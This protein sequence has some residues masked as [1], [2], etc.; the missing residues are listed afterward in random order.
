MKNLKFCNHLKSIFGRA[1]N[2]SCDTVAVEMVS[3]AEVKKHRFFKLAT[4]TLS[5]PCN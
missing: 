3:S 2:F 1:G 5:V 4:T